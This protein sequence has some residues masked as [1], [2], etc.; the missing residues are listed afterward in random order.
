[1]LPGMK[2]CGHNAPNLGTGNARTPLGG[3]GWRRSWL[4]TWWLGCLVIAGLVAN[5]PG[6]GVA[7]PQPFGP[8][9][10]DRQRAAQARE[11]FGFIHFTVNTF[12]GREWG[13]GDEPESLFNPTD[14]S[15][16]QIAQTARDAGMRGLILTCK[17]HDG[18]CL[19]PS[20]YTDHSVKNSPWKNG[21]GDVVRELSDA[22]RQAGL[23]FGIY[24]SPWDRHSAVY[25]QPAYL[26]YYR[27]QL[28]ELLTHYGPVF[29]VWFDG[30]NGG[31]GYY[32]GAR[33]T[34]HIDRATF[35]HW[36]ETWSIVRELMPDAVMFS[37]AGPDVRWVGNERGLA[38]DPCW[39]TLNVADF[40]P[41]DAD[42]ARL[43]SG[44]RFGTNWLPAECDV[45]IRPGWFYHPE[46][47]QQVKTP[48]Q[49]LD[50]YYTSVGR[51]ANLNLNLPPDRR[52]RIA[53]ADVQSLREFRRRL[54]ATFAHDLADEAT[55]SASNTRGGA[56]HFAPT[57]LVHHRPGVYWA[58]DDAV[59]TPE[60]ILNFPK[61]TT[62]NVISL[63]EYLPLG[64]RVAAFALDSWQHGQ[65]VPF[66][67]G[68]SI[69]N[70][71]LIRGPYLNTTQIRLRITQCP[72]CPALAELG[73]FAE[74]VA[75]TT[76]P[77]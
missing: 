73:V 44:D 63:R 64:Q 56:K 42:P 5:V 29:E 2:S 1:M 41:G 13:A 8:V 25:G 66:A 50:I 21:Q 14:F 6:A 17:H 34:R 18:F 39:A 40:I 19:W 7:P 52:G 27:Q 35:Y 57:N 43:N 20:Q 62:F 53:D 12:T 3:N 70:H 76:I 60:V 59:N 49:L 54:D 33:E 23:K 61:P 28:R 11:F 75:Q 16:R 38:G 47:D 36:P 22:C 72:V 51:G 26:T 9:P 37:D 48:G 4:A 32:G 24:L 71:R 67:S 58:T 10:S 74:P 69:G 46:E 31:D 30:A 15:A 65:W 77:K 45:S 55:I 68:T